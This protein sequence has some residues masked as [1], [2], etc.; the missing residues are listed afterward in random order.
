MDFIQAH[1]VSIMV[2]NDDNDSATAPN[3]TSLDNSYNLWGYEK[4]PN[5]VFRP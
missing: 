2:G 5:F 4:Y 3:D 1:I